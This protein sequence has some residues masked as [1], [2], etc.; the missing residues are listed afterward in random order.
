MSERTKIE[1]REWK[2][3]YDKKLSICSLQL[4]N[5]WH[6]IK[7]FALLPGTRPRSAAINAYLGARYS[8]SDNSIW[9][10]AEEILEKEIDPVERLEKIFAGYGHKSVGDMADI[11]VCMENIPI[12]FYEKFFHF[13][14]LGAGQARSTRYQDFSNPRYIKM[15]EKIGSKEIRREY[16]EIL[17]EEMD[18]YEKVLEPTKEY[19]SKEFDIKDINDP[20]LNSRTFDTARY[21]LPLGVKSSFGILMTARKWSEAIA[22][23]TAS[24][25]VV[26]NEVGLLLKELLA[27]S[28]GMD[29]KGYIPE[30]AELIRHTEPDTSRI[31]ST[32]E[33]LRYL[34]KIT[35]AQ[36]EKEISENA[37]DDFTVEIGTPQDEYLISNYEALINPLGSVSEMTYENKDLLKVSEILSKYHDR[38][39]ILGNVGNARPYLFDGFCDIGALRDIN[40]HRSMARF[41]PLFNDIDMEKEL[42]RENKNCFYI[43]PYLYLNR[44]GNIR[45][46]YKEYLENTYERIKKWRKRALK[47]MSQ[48]VVDEY[49]KYLLPLAHAT[50]YRFGAD[51]DALQY[52]VDLRIRNGGHIAYRELTYAWMA[53]ASLGDPLLEKFLRKSEKPDFKSK[54]QFSDRK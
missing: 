37:V 38:H 28:E 36:E 17:I 31:K 50:R 7:V 15:P 34:E 2:F 16:E 10:I 29:T 30:A 47:V 39:H 35:P 1:K 21:L 25:G 5:W 13:N 45:N 24:E 27:P 32:K 54:E 46:M 6:D 40:R 49:T 18:N 42:Q 20:C 22:L 43:C 19:L 8:R 48:T 9:E 12:Y 3:R 14:P 4:E 44:S 26:D 11:F 33:I 52:I 53:K 51:L 23:L 41:I